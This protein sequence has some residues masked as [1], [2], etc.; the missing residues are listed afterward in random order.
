MFRACYDY[1]TGFTNEGGLVRAVR[2]FLNPIA[3]NPI[4]GGLLQRRKM[5]L[6]NL[7][8]AYYMQA[9]KLPPML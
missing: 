8:F 2:R 6:T 1:V 4:H 9:C 3:M 5:N 7:P